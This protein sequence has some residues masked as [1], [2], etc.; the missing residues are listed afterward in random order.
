MKAFSMAL[1]AMLAVVPNSGGMVSV[2]YAGSLIRVMEG[3][4]A[5]ALRD[6]TGLT[7]AGEGKGSKALAHLIAAGLRTPDVFISAD[8]KLLD[9]LM[10]GGENAFISGYTVF[11]SARMVVAFSAKSPHRDL[12]DDVVHG[13]RTI[14]DVLS[15]P[16]VRV[17]RTD[18]QLDPK[19]ERTVR[20][21]QLLAAHFHRPS[22][23]AR[24]LVKAQM[25]PEEDLGVR[26]ESGELDAGF[27]YSTEIPGRGLQGIE[28]PGDT[29]LS[30]EI[31][32][33]LAVM[34]HAPHPAAAKTF[35]E[36]V[37]S[38]GGKAVLEQAGVSYFTHPR[39]A[40]T[41]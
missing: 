9:E 25:F 38:G 22:E 14:L 5:S 36:F 4:M 21:L 20:V 30:Q 19:G 7:F 31:S 37:M 15:N 2:A 10:R 29:N 16:D 3:P 18:P 1:A 32:Y 39:I 34:R 35:A 26:V 27:F 28:L 24:L 11:G 6:Q 12:F 41:P 8:P 40:G 33:A 17:G 23:A 13:K